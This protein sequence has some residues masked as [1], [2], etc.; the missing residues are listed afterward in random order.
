MEK[1]IEFAIS[2]SGFLSLIFCIILSKNKKD[3]VVFEKLSK[4][5]FFQD[6]KK[7]FAIS[8]FS[9]NLLSELEVWDE[10]I[11]NSACPIHNIYIYED[12]SKDSKFLKDSCVFEN[13]DEPMGFMLDSFILKKKLFEK[14]GEEKIIFDS[15]Y[16]DFE[17]LEN[18]QN[19]ITLQN[20]QTD[21][22]AKIISD[23]FFVCE[24]KNS[25]LHELFNIKSF[26]FNYH[27]TALLFKIHHSN[28][29]N[30]SALEKFFDDGMI[31]TLPLKNQNESSIVWILK[32][33]NLDLIG[34]MSQEKLIQILE[35]KIDYNLGKIEILQGQKIAKYPL[36]LKFLSRIS[37]KNVFFIGDS[38]HAIHPVAG[39]G[40]NL[41]ISDL[42][43]ILKGNPSFNL[44]YIPK[45]QEENPL[46]KTL[47]SKFSKKRIFLNLYSM[48]FNLQM[49]CFTHF[50]NLIFLNQN[51]ILKFFRNKAIWAFGESKILNKF[52]KNNATGTK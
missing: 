2:G 7:S 27:Q 52:L 17:I 6:D 42:M 43:R 25:K 13:Q 48:F 24:G 18:Q 21:E 23:F 36:S 46:L 3:F 31:A 15:S 12:S 39:Q 11:Q 37:H 47:L 5:I 40:L 8:K 49:I 45:I 26:E 29:H 34:R 33:E 19:L 22:K 4:D 51:P 38:A 10:E 20:F 50:L 9:A 16:V 1:K 28:S 44:D 32:N 35:K 30:F 41:G 14:I